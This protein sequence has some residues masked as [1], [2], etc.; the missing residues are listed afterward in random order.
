MKIILSFLFLISTY[1][2]SANFQCSSYGIVDVFVNGEIDG[3]YTIT[4]IDLPF[5]ED[6]KT[7]TKL[8]VDINEGNQSFIFH[9]ENLN[10]NPDYWIKIETQNEIGW[11]EMDYRGVLK[12]HEK[13]HCVLNP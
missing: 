10:G 11:M 5:R 7:I 3:N 12:N 13:T 6:I 9:A 1:A 8:N 2:F 4:I